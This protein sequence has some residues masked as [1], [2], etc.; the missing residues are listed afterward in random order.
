M[1]FAELFSKKTESDQSEIGNDLSALLDHIVRI[2][3]RYSEAS[4]EL[5]NARQHLQ[6][7]QARDLDGE[8]ADVDAAVSEVVAE[9]EKV[10]GI[11]SILEKSKSKAVAMVAASTASQRK[12][13]AEV[14]TEIAKIR[15]GIDIRRIRNIT[16]FA[17]KHD[18]RVAWPTKT[19]AGS[20]LLP[21]L[22][23]DGDA[24]N[25]VADAVVTA[26][27]VDEDASRLDELCR[28]RTRLNMVVRSQ[29]DIAVDSLLAERR[30]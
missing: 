15:E 9:K 22:S 14:E 12:R 16:E 6:N 13:L 1:K 28:E 25:E 7:A 8:R 26:V 17:R 23:I 19:A 20:I 29:P 21:A 24:L 27:H 10:D 5:E 11:K 2:E 3:K 4:S 18:L 30:R